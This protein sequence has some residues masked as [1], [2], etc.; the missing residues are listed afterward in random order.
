MNL[1]AVAV[2]LSAALAVG[3]LGGAVVAGAG[4]DERDWE[5]ASS[6]TQRRSYIAAA[7]LDGVLYAAGGMVGE[8]GRPLSTFS[9]YDPA[10]DLWSTLPPLPVPTRAGAAAALGGELFV[11]GGTTA[12][13]NTT[14]VWAYRPES[15]T[16]RERAPLPAAR[17]N[18]EAVALGGRLYVVGG[19]LAGRERDELFAYD[20]G[21]DRWSLAGRLPRATH[22]F[23]LVAYAGEIWVI[24]GRRG[25]RVLREVWIYDPASAE[26]RPGP[27][28][29]R[30]MELLGAAA[31]SGEIH[32][33][34]EE[35]YQVLDVA[36]GEWRLGPRP[37]V[38][39]HALE[40][41][42]VGEALLT[43]GGCTTALRDTHVVEHLRLD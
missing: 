24:G 28:L 2:A 20:P 29:R 8:T 3:A 43:V 41:F 26:W 7:P 6:M 12:A 5:L 36:S 40:A 16:W 31:A 4:R 25:E 35:T 39:R 9:R 22:A 14:A 21:R 18:H 32:A 17:F 13:G 37:L 30:P 11:A 27:S 15:R 10:R 19:Y 23:G 42:V 38:T 33:V 1:R 34:W